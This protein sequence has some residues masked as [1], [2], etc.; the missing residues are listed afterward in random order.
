MSNSSKFN[1]EE[2]ERWKTSV[3]E[4]NN[5]LEEL[6]KD[7]AAVMT[8]FEMGDTIVD[9]LAELSETLTRSFN[10]LMEAVKMAI[11]A[12]QEVIKKVAESVENI[13]S[14]IAHTMFGVANA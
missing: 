1:K 5:T 8:G 2:A 10:K 14:D 13:I 9:K 6:L 7:V 11:E 12:L 4:L 3:E